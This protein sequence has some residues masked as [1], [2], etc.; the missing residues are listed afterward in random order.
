MPDYK[1]L[2]DNLKVEYEAYQRVSEKHIQELCEMN[3]KLENSNNSLFNIV[4][5]SKYINTFFSDDNLISMINDMIIGILGVS[6]S[7]IFLMENDE[8]IIKATNIEDSK[9]NLSSEEIKY[10]YNEQEFLINSKDPIKQIG[11][12]RSNIHSAMGVP[13]FLRDKFMGYIVVEHKVY[14]FMTIELKMFLKSIANQI[15]I[16]IENSFLYKQ[17]EKLTQTDSLMNIYNRKYFF[18]YMEKM[19]KQ[20]NH[21]KFAIVMI[22]I[23]NF[24]KVNDNFGHQFGDKVLINTAK[25]INGWLGNNDIIARYGGEE[26]I[27]CIKDFDEEI[28]VYNKV[29]IIR[30][31]IESSIISFQGKE[32]SVTASFG[33]S[34]FPL[35]SQNISELIKIADDLLYNA[36]KLG[37]NK[38]ISAHDED[39]KGL[40]YAE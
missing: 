30:R 4:E 15:A 37:K 24:K 5:I 40:K 23:D 14:N 29:D 34:Y 16:S 13:I 1:K 12:Q 20:E 33:I 32:N 19:M 22:D 35:N 8:L 18:D 27:L 7:T 9:I 26:I 25:V 28:S 31:A 17:L 38:V 2:Y 21:D 6:Y 39:F 11:S 10:V 3:V 36:K